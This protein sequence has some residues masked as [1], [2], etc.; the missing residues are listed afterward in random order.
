MQPGKTSKKLKNCGGLDLHI[1]ARVRDPQNFDKSLSWWMP[2]IYDE[3]SILPQGKRFVSRA[4]TLMSTFLHAVFSFSFTIY[5][6]KYI[7]IVNISLLFYFFSSLR[8]GE[9]STVF[10][11]VSFDFNLSRSPKIQHSFV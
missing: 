9:Q 4:K 6:G 2:N 11:I 7:V 5:L 10:C 3:W 1:A 8:R